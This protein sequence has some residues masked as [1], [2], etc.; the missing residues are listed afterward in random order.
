MAILRGGN[1]RFFRF[2]FPWRIKSGSWS[3]ISRKDPFSIPGCQPVW[4]IDSGRTGLF[5]MLPDGGSTAAG[6]AHHHHPQCPGETRRSW[7]GHTWMKITI[8][9]LFD[10]YGGHT[11]ARFL[12]GTCPPSEGV[13]HICADLMGKNIRILLIW[14]CFV[15]SLSWLIPSNEKDDKTSPNWVP[16]ARNRD[17]SG[18]LVPKKTNLLVRFSNIGYL[19]DFTANHPI[20]IV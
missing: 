7:R 17:R 6:S 19:R 3:R 4:D 9:S 20:I 14:V 18:N 2:F 11:L 13:I 1:I 8:P 12:I 5:F 15:P 10:T 16:F